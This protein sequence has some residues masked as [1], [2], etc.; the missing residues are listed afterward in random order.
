MVGGEL[1]N[2]GFRSNKN[3]HWNP[4]LKG[5]DTKF[6]SGKE[7]LLQTLKDKKTFL[8]FPRGDGDLF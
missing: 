8:S 7:I 5:Y 2:D 4:N 1:R 3:S 6:I